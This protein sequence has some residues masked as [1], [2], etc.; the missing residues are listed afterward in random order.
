MGAQY[1]GGPYILVKHLGF[2]SKNQKNPLLLLAEGGKKKSF[3]NM[4]YHLEE[5]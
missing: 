2:H 5:T 4:P 1:L 3:W